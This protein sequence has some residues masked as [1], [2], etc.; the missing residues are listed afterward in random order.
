MPGRIAGLATLQVEGE[1]RAEQP[2]GRQEIATIEGSD[3]LQERYAVTG[4]VLGK[5]DGASALIEGQF[6]AR[7][8]DP[9]APSPD[10]VGGHADGL[11]GR[12][13]PR[14][15]ADGGLAHAD[16]VVVTALRL[17]DRRP[18]GIGPWPVLGGAGSGQAREE[19][20]RLLAAGVRSEI[21]GVAIGLGLAVDGLGRLGDQLVDL[22]L[23]ALEATSGRLARAGGDG[24][25]GGRAHHLAGDPRLRS[26]PLAEISVQLA[27]RHAGLGDLDLD[28]AAPVVGV[29]RGRP[30]GDGA[31]LQVGKPIEQ[32]AGHHLAGQAA[33]GQIGR[34]GKGRDRDAV[35]LVG[36]PGHHRHRA[37]YRQANDRRH[38]LQRQG[39]P[40]LPAAEAQA[41]QHQF[42]LFVQV[43]GLQLGQQ[44]L[45]V[46]EGVEL[47]VGLGAGA[48]VAR[49]NGHGRRGRDR[50]Y[51]G[52]GRAFG[53]R[54]FDALGHRP[55]PPERRYRIDRGWQSLGLHPAL[56]PSSSLIARSRSRF[57]C[58]L[59]EAVRGSR[60]VM[61]TRLG[62]L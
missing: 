13:E 51:A 10:R 23:G 52:L 30:A 20:A 58:S 6:L 33:L 5:A 40:V 49:T 29:A 56:S 2:R 24:D 32:L 42:A 34:H 53:F 14:I 44:G 45:A 28:V 62:A 9:D 1:H 38:R 37:G 7:V 55:I 60:S 3:R 59:P 19:G 57:F 35:V 41:R 46:E 50:R 54:L 43:L 18:A 8:V 47:G 4:L 16:G 26:Q 39:D 48:L 31:G 25:L 15:Q 22:G 17:Q 36:L 12:I 11:I 21:D 61:I 27:D